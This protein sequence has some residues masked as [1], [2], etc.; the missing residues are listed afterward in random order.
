M[1]SS[2]HFIERFLLNL[3]YH[4]GQKW[5]KVFLHLGGGEG[6]EKDCPRGGTGGWLLAKFGSSAERDLLPSAE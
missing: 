6:A 1:M 3:E 5:S 4:M 2:V